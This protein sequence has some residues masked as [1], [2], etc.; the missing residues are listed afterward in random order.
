MRVIVSCARIGRRIRIAVIVERNRYRTARA[1]KRN[2][3]LIPLR[4]GHPARRHK[5]APTRKKDEQ[6]PENREAELGAERFHR[7]MAGRPE[8]L[9]GKGQ[10]SATRAG[11]CI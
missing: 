4:N 2:G 5:P 3:N 10:R 1:A 11:N 8:A 6:Q 7:E 9:R